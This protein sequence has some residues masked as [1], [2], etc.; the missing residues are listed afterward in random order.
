MALTLTIPGGP[1]QLNGNRVEAEVSTDTITGELYKLLLKTTSLDDSFP[2]SLVGL[3]SSVVF[4]YELADSANHRLYVYVKQ[5]CG[6]F[7]NPVVYFLTGL[8]K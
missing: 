8:H 7:Q 6:K 2:G 1:V 4:S 5:I 3:V